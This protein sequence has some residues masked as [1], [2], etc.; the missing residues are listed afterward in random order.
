MP[1]DE[2]KD[3]FSYSLM[4]TKANR[5]LKPHSS[6]LEKRTAF[7]PIVKLPYTP[8]ESRQGYHNS[9]E[10]VESAE[11]ESDDEWI[12]GD[13]FPQHVIRNDRW[14]TVTKDDLKRCITNLYV[15]A[16]ALVVQAGQRVMMA[17]EKHISPPMTPERRERLA[18]AIQTLNDAVLEGK[19]EM[20]IFTADTLA[21]DC[22]CGKED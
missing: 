19:A 1:P 10:F 6:S 5:G 11:E 18:K 21:I 8:S 17:R 13:K 2:D 3:Y 20:K 14:K 7:V 12:S 15:N 16:D 4:L 9:E 22:T